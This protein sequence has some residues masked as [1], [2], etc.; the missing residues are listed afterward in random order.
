[1]TSSNVIELKVSMLMNLKNFNVNE[2][3]LPMVMN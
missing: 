1:M 3:K 2:L